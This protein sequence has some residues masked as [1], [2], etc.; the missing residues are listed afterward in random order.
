ME[1][2]KKDPEFVYN[3]PKKRAEDLMNAFLDPNIDAIFSS[4]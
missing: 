1:N 3:N 2:A 4:I